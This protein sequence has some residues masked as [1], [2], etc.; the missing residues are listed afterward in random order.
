ME[1]G[2]TRALQVTAMPD[3]GNVPPASVTVVVVNWN[4]GQLLRRCIEHLLRQTHSAQHIV[5]VDNGS[6]DGSADFLDATPD[7]E[8]FRL[9]CNVG[10]ASANNIAIQHCKTEFVALLNPDAFPEPDWLERLL[11]AAVNYPGATAFGSR[12]LRD[13]SATL[14]DGIGDAY[15]V[16]GLAWRLGCGQ[17]LHPQD[18]RPR[19][20]FAACAAAALYRHDAL[21]RTGGFDEAYFCYFEDVDLGFRLRLDGGECRYVPDAVVHH[22]GSAITGR[23]SDFSVYHGHR[24]LVWTF[25]KN[26]PGIWFWV[27]LP[28]HLL[29]NVLVLATYTALGRGACLYRAKRDAVRDLG[30]VWEQRRA[31]QAVRRVPA[32][33]VLA[34][35]EVLPWR[36]R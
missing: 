9:G 29:M 10:F 4:A 12:L 19:T 32:R 15:H 26:M 2:L 1:V 6:N 17:N 33:T 34:A 28:I 21:L 8:L 7:I 11:A 3:G 13:G 20:I 25:V 5:V 27:L 14:L 30:R 35:M 16:S 36:R 22:I 31:V 18:L 24:N 23:T